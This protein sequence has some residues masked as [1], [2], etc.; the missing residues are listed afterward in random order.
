MISLVMQLLVNQLDPL[1]EQQ[2]ADFNNLQLSSHHAEVALSQG[3]EA[4]QLSLG[5]T[6]A[7]GSPFT[8]SGNVATTYM[9]QM[10]MAMGKLMTLEDFLRQV[11]LFLLLLPVLCLNCLPWICCECLFSCLNMWKSWARMLV[12]SLRIRLDL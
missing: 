4:L 10:A 5:E 6:L 9:C 2:V 12:M 7:M 3:M 1:S 11:T 8:E